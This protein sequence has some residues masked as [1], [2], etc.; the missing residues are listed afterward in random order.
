M[1]LSRLFD[2][3]DTG[4]MLTVARNAEGRPDAFIQWTPAADIDGWSLD[5]MR[6]RTDVDLP[7]GLMD[8]LIVETISYVA[9]R[10]GRGLGLN[11]AMFRSVVSGEKQTPLARAS[12][13]VLRRVSR[14]AQIESLWRFNAKYFP[15]WAPRYAVVG[16]FD[17]WASQTFVMAGAEG[18][19]EVPIFGRFLNRGRS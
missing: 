18:A 8:F 16:S 15:A 1:T 14:R 11:F 2:P 17:V 6:R 19:A 4:L 12:Q 9:E 3:D 10:G 7:N 5:V 13:S